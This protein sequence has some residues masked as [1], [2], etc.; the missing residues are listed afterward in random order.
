MHGPP[1]SRKNFGRES[2]LALA[3]LLGGNLA[4]AFGPLFVRLADSEAG[5]GPIASGFWRL[6]LAIPFLLLLARPRGGAAALRADRTLLLL[7]AVGGFFFAADLAAW[8][9]GIMRT[10][11]ANSTLLGNSASLF[12]PVYGFLVARH[13]PSRGQGLALALA[14]LGA[15]LLMGRS[16]ELSTRYLAGDL[17]CLLAGVL[18]TVYLISI[19]RARAALAPWPVLALSTVAGAL[20]MLLFALAAGE[21]VWPDAWWPLFGLALFS[22][23]VGQG[24]LVIAMGHFSP[25]VVGIAFLTQPVIAAAIGWIVYG[26]A[27]AP[28]DL[29]GAVAIAA[30]IVLVR[31]G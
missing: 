25:L 23:L 18:Y 1:A 28:A 21:T 4:L 24:L 15:V 20:P 9:L 7:V 13:W 31:R 3:A 10:K 17:L 6:A 29:V 22:Q 14:G 2:G 11:L 19:D 8:H 5:V 16:Y 30:A 12:F 27:L 26:E